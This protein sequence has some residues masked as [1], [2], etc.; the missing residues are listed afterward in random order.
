VLFRRCCVHHHSHRGICDAHQRK[1]Q[2]SP[3]RSKSLAR[4]RGSGSSFLLYLLLLVIIIIIII[5]IIIP[6]IEDTE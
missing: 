6:L 5:I 4:R 1:T 3:T 2:S